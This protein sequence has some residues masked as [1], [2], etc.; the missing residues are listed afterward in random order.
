MAE[1]SSSSLSRTFTDSVAD[2]IF[3]TAYYAASFSPSRDELRQDLS[4]WRKMCFIGGPGSCGGGRGPTGGGC[5]RILAGVSKE[6]DQRRWKDR[7]FPRDPVRTVH[8]VLQPR[9][10]WNCLLKVRGRG[11]KRPPAKARQVT[12]NLFFSS[13]P[14]VLSFHFLH[15]KNIIGLGLSIKHL[16]SCSLHAQA[17]WSTFK[18]WS[19]QN[20]VT[21]WRRLLEW[22]QC[23]HAG[24]W[25]PECHPCGWK[26]LTVGSAG[27]V[28]LLLFAAL[29]SI[30]NFLVAWDPLWRYSCWTSFLPLTLS[31]II[32]VSLF[33]RPKWL[34]PKAY[35]LSFI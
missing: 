32:C 31:D 12:L 26:Y 17:C 27:V 18:L 7:L 2:G 29:G 8:G 25:S 20:P 28:W 30:R 19:H 11:K 9:R 22:V 6:P 3:L 21:T 23:V 24:M 5:G 10:L 15:L 1:F 13:L 14:Y 34:Q 4:E 35:F 16:W 33:S